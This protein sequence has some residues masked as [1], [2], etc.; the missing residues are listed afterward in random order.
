MAEEKKYYSSVDDVLQHTGMR[1]EDLGFMSEASARD[2]IENRLV[3][4]KDLIDHDRNRD[5]HAEVGAGERDKVPPGIHSIAL[6]IMSNMVGQ[7]VLRRTTPIIKKDDF[8]VQLVEDRVFTE[9]IK[10]DLRRY[11]AKPRLR[12]FIPGGEK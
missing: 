3:E 1:I 2:W 9:A 10:K 4:I 5:Y 7:A 6:R 12:M 8:S 11:L